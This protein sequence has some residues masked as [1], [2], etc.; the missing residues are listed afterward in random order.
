MVATRFFSTLKSTNIMQKSYQTTEQQQC[1]GKTSNN[2]NRST[3]T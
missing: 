1:N 2:R 3:R